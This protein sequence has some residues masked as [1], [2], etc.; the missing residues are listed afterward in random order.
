MAYKPPQ[1]VNT[2][3]P[4]CKKF[5]TT[6]CKWE[7][8]L[9]KKGDVFKH[10]MLVLKNAKPTIED[11]L[12]A[13]LHDVGKPKTQKFMD[14]RITFYGHEKASAEIALAMLR[15]LKF[16]NTTIK[17]VVTMVR[18]HMRPYQL[19]GAS[20]KAYRKF[21]R[22]V[23]IE[24]VDSILDLAE[25]DGLGRLP[26]SE[27]IIPELRK[28]INEI[29]NSRPP[30]TKPILNGKEIAEILGISPGPKI[31]EAVRFLL[32]LE[33]EYASKGRDLTKEIAEEFL[34]DKFEE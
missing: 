15:R 11:Q 6:R 18:M 1:P 5:R 28:K 20:G 16:D 9:I 23:G 13:L 17:K 8:E 7:P 4:H 10:T 2:L 3:C 12:A 33:D 30:S 32:D 26:E 24:M 25:A 34:K 22:E 27:N 19:H 29:Q 14:D 21:I 31:G